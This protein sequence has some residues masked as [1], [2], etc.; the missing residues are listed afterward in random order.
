[1]NNIDKLT[2][3][4]G[5][6]VLSAVGASM[7][8][9]EIQA[10]TSIIVTVAGFLISVLI[11]LIVKLVKKVKE[12]KKDGK[13]DKDELSD[14][15]STGKEIVDKTGSLIEKVKEESDKKSEGEK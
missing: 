11:P 5:G 12:A 8:V 2:C 1:M 4:V 3:G 15:I 7:S 6:T 9:T 10:I 14:I 13:I